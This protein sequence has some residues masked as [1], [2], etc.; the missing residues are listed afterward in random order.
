MIFYGQKR[1][2]FLFELSLSDLVRG[3]AEAEPTTN[4]VGGGGG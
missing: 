1:I 3:G 4:F 2:W